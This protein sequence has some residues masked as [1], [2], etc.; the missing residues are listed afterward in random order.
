MFRH[1]TISVFIFAPKKFRVHIK[2]KSLTLYSYG[3]QYVF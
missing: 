1:R 2:I 3:C